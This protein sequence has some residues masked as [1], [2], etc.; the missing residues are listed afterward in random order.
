MSTHASPP[1]AA[2]VSG[3]V[4]ALL[5]ALA[6][7]LGAAFVLAPGWLAAGP[8][9]RGFGERR[10]LVATLRQ[11]FVEYW[12]SGDRGF[13]PELERVVD[14]WYRYHVVKA[15]CAALLLVVL[16]VLGVLLWKAFLRG[17]TA[18][19]T[20]ALAS[21]G[22]VVTVL[23]LGSLAALMANV[24]GATAPFSSV[25]SMLPLGAPDGQL[26]GVAGQVRQD[27]AHYSGADE[28]HTP[29]V[30]VMVNDF[31]RYHAVLAVAASLVAVV[32]IG[33]SVLAWKR[34]A[35]ARARGAGRQ[36]RRVRRLLGALGVVSVLLSCATI[37]IVVANVG[38]AADPAPALLGFF[39]GGW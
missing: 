31:G 1:P 2:A 22:V 13:S 3:R 5:T 34:F 36:E 21:A 8:S 6:V 33:L 28:Q 15:V 26:A 19:R 14:Y 30:E 23:A 24:Q 10:N 4:L 20:G 18:L 27:L 16:V 29:A 11:G 25:V 12:K 37:I 17:T 7:A 32:L 35:G 39:E 9:D 38:T